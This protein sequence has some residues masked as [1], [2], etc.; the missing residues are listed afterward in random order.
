MILGLVKRKKK[1]L[2]HI[3]FV[4]GQVVDS[5]LHV[6]LLVQL[7]SSKCSWKVCPKRV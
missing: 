1:V 2:V 7:S 5:D 3:K 4:G 6:P